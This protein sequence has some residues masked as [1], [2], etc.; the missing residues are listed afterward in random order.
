MTG[1]PHD[2]ARPNWITGDGVAS[3]TP[4]LRVLAELERKTTGMTM[5]ELTH[6]EADIGTRHLARC[7]AAT[8]CVTQERKGLGMTNETAQTNVGSNDRLNGE[9]TEGD[10]FIAL[11][12]NLRR[13]VWMLID[14]RRRQDAKWGGPEHDDLRGTS[15]FAQLAQDYAGW[16]RVMA[17]MGSY[18]KAQNRMVQVS[19]LALADVERLMRIL[20]RC[21]PSVLEF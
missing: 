9:Q 19:A 11:P 5:S 3:G 14:E 10:Q 20:D 1:G 7:H 13:S 8:A 16:A 6:A 12:K 17:C 15:D 4:S 18:D 2:S 21:K